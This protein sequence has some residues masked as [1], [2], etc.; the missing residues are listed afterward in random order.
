MQTLALSI[1]VFLVGAGLL[2]AVQWSVL[3]LGRVV[4]RFVRETLVPE[5]HLISAGVGTYKYLGFDPAFMRDIN[6]WDRNTVETLYFSADV[7]LRLGHGNF[8]QAHRDKILRFLSSCYDLS[9]GL[10]RLSPAPGKSSAHYSHCALA[11]VKFTDG[12]G[13]GIPL[14]T[15]RAGEVLGEPSDL[16]AMSAFRCAERIVM[17]ELPDEDRSVIELYCATSVLW[18]LQRNDLLGGL[19]RKRLLKLVDS[20]FVKPGGAAHARGFANNPTERHPQLGATYFVVKLLRFMDV[21]PLEH[22]DTERVAGFLHMCWSEEAGAFSAVPGSLPTLV[23]TKL[24]LDIRRRLSLPLPPSP[25]RLLRFVQ[26]CSTTY[27]FGFS[28]GL[29]SNPYALRCAVEI[30]ETI[31]GEVDG[32]ADRLRERIRTLPNTLISKFY[33]SKAGAFRGYAASWLGRVVAT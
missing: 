18:N 31:S 26:A 6:S 5:R 20:L 9:T 25:E 29:L 1:V 15:G 14:G 24:G 22:V 32:R 23:H 4:R 12:V 7:L 11:V 2:L 27:G 19:D 33:D 16:L 21:D 17:G 3:G 8:L 30:L 10:Y 28:P 13:C